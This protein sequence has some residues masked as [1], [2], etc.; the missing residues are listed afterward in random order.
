MAWTGIVITD[1]D[2][3]NV[4]TITAI[5][6]QGLGDEFTYSRRGRMTNAE[7]DA[8]VTEAKD[9]LGAHQ[10]KGTIDVNFSGILTTAL[11]A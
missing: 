1:T 2:K 3:T 6:N 8:F 7:K 4:G 5:W 10:N 11:N 9:A